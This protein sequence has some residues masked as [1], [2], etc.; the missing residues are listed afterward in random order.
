MRILVQRVTR[1]AVRV[2]ERTTGSIGAGLLALVA[3]TD[4]DGDEQISWMADKLLGLRVFADADDKMNLALADVGGS[5]LVVSQFTL[6]GDAI[7]GRR[8]SFVDAAPPAVAESLYERFV[9]ALR[10]RGAKVE[11]GSFGASMQVE[12]VNDGPVTIWIER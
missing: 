10:E 1:A 5:L 4:A 3:F 7:R 6:Y 2:S 11:T 8:P 9:A 12:L